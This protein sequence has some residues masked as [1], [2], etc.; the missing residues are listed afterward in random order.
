VILGWDLA[1]GAGTSTLTRGG[2]VRH[3]SL[4]LLGGRSGATAGAH[5]STLF[6]VDRR[7]VLGGQAALFL[8]LDRGWLRGA[9]VMAMANVA[10]GRAQG[11]QL[12]LAVNVAGAS[13]EGAQLAALVNVVRGDLRG[14]QLSPAVGVALGELRGA[15]LSV[16]ASAA[17][18]GRG[19]QLGVANV[20]TGELRG[21]QVGVVNV[22]GEASAQVGF[23]NVARRAGTQVGFLSLSRDSKAL[24]DLWGNE[25]GF[26]ELGLLLR[27]RY[28]HTIYALGIQVQEIATPVWAV[29]FGVGAHNPFRRRFFIDVDVLGHYVFADMAALSLDVMLQARVSFGVQVVSWLAVWAGVTYRVMWSDTGDASQ[30]PLFGDAVLFRDEVMVIRG[31]PGFAIGVRF[32]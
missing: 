13:F 22:A 30:Y 10:N 27:N 29:G 31:W 5:L 19:A 26:V 4:G 1:P 21:A 32:L 15:Q 12:A 23:V 17:R 6:S 2:D 3:L 24:V 25:T 9:Q 11:A 20:A 7:Y 8:N 18:G 16:L 14:A 28:V